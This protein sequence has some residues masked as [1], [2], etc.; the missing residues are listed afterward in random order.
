MAERP[1]YYIDALH[2]ITLGDIV[3]ISSTRGAEKGKRGA[4]QNG[5]RPGYRRVLSGVNSDDV[6]FYFQRMSGVL[7]RGFFA[8]LLQGGVLRAAVEPARVIN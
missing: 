1:L 5:I 2:T 4:E 8:K 6:V 7:V 3:S